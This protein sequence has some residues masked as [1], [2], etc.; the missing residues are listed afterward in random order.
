MVSGASIETGK[1]KPSI[2]V[3]AVD[4]ARLNGEKVADELAGDRR[5]RVVSTNPSWA[6]ILAAADLEK[7]DVAILCPFFDSDASMGFQVARRLRELHPAIRIV[8]LLERSEPS[9]VLEAFRVGV[10][11]ILSRAEAPKYLPRCISCV[12]EGQVWA[13]S[14]ELKYLIDDVSASLH[15]SYPVRAGNISGLSKRE[16]DVVQ[17]VADGLSNRDIAHRLNLTEHTVKNY[18]FR[19]FDKLEVS[20]RVEVVL[21]AFGLPGA[22]PRK[23]VT[24]PRKGRSRAGERANKS[25]RKNPIERKG[26]DIAPARQS[27][28]ELPL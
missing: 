3:L 24:K 20:S 10:S 28:K 25:A 18:L 11:G 8:M 6:A 9:S 14:R 1:V 17:G 2:R 5:F 26:S 16:Q 22:S 4:S 27:R 23:S 15:A 21:Y 19:V 13:N 7:P 12:H